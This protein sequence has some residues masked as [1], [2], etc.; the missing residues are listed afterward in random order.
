M[1]FTQLSDHEINKTRV[2]KIIALLTCWLPVQGNLVISGNGIAVLSA[3]DD[4]CTALSCMILIK[5]L[6]FAHIY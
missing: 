5:I 3:L 2:L 1:F 4:F 6:K